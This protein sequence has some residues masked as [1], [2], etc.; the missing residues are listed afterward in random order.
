MSSN[1][2]VWYQQGNWPLFGAICML[3]V[4]NAITLLAIYLKAG[5]DFKQQT[6]L[7]NRNFV[8]N[9]LSEFY[10]PLVSALALNR[11]VFEKAGPSTFPRDAIRRESAGALWQSLKEK[12]ILPNNSTIAALLSTKTHLISTEDDLA[13]YLPLYTHIRMYEAF[14]DDPNELYSE[15]QF[16]K[17]IELHIDMIRKLLLAQLR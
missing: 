13:R 9:Q 12:V 6:R 4:T 15:F 14:L 7:A 3:V 11:A 16:P 1:L 17:G 10:D 2:G 5:A 8:R